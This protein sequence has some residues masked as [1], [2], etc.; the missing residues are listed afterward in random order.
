MSGNPYQCFS[1]VTSLPFSLWF[2]SSSLQLALSKNY[3]VL[4]RLDA[5]WDLS[6]MAQVSS[7][8]EKSNSSSLWWDADI[9]SLSEVKCKRNSLL[10]SFI[11]AQEWW[12]H[13]SGH[14]ACY[15]P[16]AG[17]DFVEMLLSLSSPWPDLQPCGRNWWGEV[18]RIWQHHPLL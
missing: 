10:E 5:V 9:S 11:T 12:L 17:E 8:Q 15:L 18:Q 16:A 3:V 6:V 13:G 7:F 4:S 2:T 14:C 1:R